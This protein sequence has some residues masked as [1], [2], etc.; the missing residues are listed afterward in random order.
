MESAILAVLLASL[1]VPAAAHSWTPSLRSTELVAA[2]PHDDTDVALLHVHAETPPHLLRI[3]HLSVLYFAAFLAIVIARTG[4]LCAEKCG[5]RGERRELPLRDAPKWQEQGVRT[6]DFR[7]EAACDVLFYV[8]ALC[9]LFLAARVWALRGSQDGTLVPW[10]THSMTVISYAIL[11]E[12]VLKVVEPDDGRTWSAWICSVVGAMAGFCMHA[13]AAVIVVTILT[14]PFRPSLAMQCITLLTAIYFAVHALLAVHRGFLWAMGAPE[15]LY[16]DRTSKAFAQ[17]QHLKETL[18]LFPMLCIIL[19]CVRMRSLELGL[20]APLA[21]TQH[22]M[23]ALSFGAGFQVF[24][25]VSQILLASMEQY[26]GKI[27]GVVLSTAET[28]CLVTVYGGAAMV[29]GELLDWDPSG[30][31]SLVEATFDAVGPIPVSMKCVTTLATLY[32]LAYL[33]VLLARC[34]QYVSAVIINREEYTKGRVEEVMDHTCKAVVF[35]PMLCMLMIT[36]RL[37]SQNLGLADPPR[38]AQMAMV[39]S[40]GAL[41]MQVL[42]APVSSFLTGAVFGE[43]SAAATESAKYCAVGFMVAH[44]LTVAVFYGALSTLLAT[45]FAPGV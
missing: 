34:F 32:F 39:T 17:V 33:S 25:V 30:K 9:I 31:V 16:S 15:T 14:S 8:P 18:A 21:T 28:L 19:V 7:L 41:V 20:G 5:G 11:V 2:Q 42:I 35:A 3:S 6:L 29:F 40:V 22:G 12:Y 13:G 24:A 43:E 10:I 23:I 27:L 45:L 1:T 44:Y 38:Y 4:L 37:R 36:L 26:C